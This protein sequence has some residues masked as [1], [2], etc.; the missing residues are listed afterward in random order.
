MLRNSASQIQT[1]HESHGD[2]PRQTLVRQWSLEFCTDD[3]LL[4]DAE[5]L[6]YSLMCEKPDSPEHGTAGQG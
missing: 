1:T 6:V 4:G 2:L 5:G 3:R